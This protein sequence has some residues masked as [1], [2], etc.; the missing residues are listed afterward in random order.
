MG[1]KETMMMRLFTAVLVFGVASAAQPPAQRSQQQ[2]V[3][4]THQ[5]DK[6]LPRGTRVKCIQNAPGRAYDIR[7]NEEFT[8]IE[9][10]GD[11]FLLI[12]EKN[13]KYRQ[14][15]NR[16][17]KAFLQVTTIWKEKEIHHRFGKKGTS[18]CQFK[19]GGKARVTRNTRQGEKIVVAAGEEVT[20]IQVEAISV[21]IRDSKGR[22]YAL[23]KGN[24]QPLRVPHQPHQP[25]Q[26]SAE[27]RLILSS[28][29]GNTSTDMYNMKV[30]RR[31]MIGKR[32][33]DVWIT[34]PGEKYVVVYDHGNNM[35]SIQEITKAGMIRRICETENDQC[36]FGNVV[37]KEDLI[38]LDEKKGEDFPDHCSTAQRAHAGLNYRYR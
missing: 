23:P 24:L 35:V 18:K 17:E 37:F 10:K 27:T 11:G 29:N 30:R 32:G 33:G 7:K 25:H 2:L 9:D 8:V 34:K 21:L 22:E 16:V 15:V 4:Q 20:V 31:V 3:E 19:V 14:A 1:A 36:E 13:N 38:L 28:W 26:L 6:L 5:L 12:Q